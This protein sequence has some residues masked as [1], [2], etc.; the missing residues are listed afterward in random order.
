[1]YG[2]GA[3][4]LSVL[5]TPTVMLSPN[6]RNLVFERVAVRET[7]TA[8]V[9]EAVRFSESVAVQ[10]TSC[11]PMGNVPPDDG[12]HATVTGDWPPAASGVV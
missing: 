11:E 10:R 6:A 8:N 9:Q 1:M 2:G 12:S 3:F 7:V 5:T 4:G